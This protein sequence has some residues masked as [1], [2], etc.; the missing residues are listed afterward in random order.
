MQREVITVPYAS[1]LSEV[2]RI[3]SD[4]RIGGAPVTDET[5]RIVGIVS[6]RDL[7][8]RYVED[9]DA[10]PRRGNASYHLSVEETQDE[11][12]DSFEVPKE[13]EDTAADVMTALIHSVDVGA[14][15]MEMAS[16][17]G[18]HRIH[19]VLVRENGKYV[20]LV[21]T[22]EILNALGA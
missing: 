8:E 5:G 7:V 6:I 15:L 12:F 19:R 4:N 16:L 9:P 11:D 2:E 21:T 14:G 13:G 3:L 10:R 22:M 1:P 20:G 18:E 17:M